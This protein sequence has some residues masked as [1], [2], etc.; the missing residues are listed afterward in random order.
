MQEIS[1]ALII[2]CSSRPVQEK[3][4]NIYASLILHRA[5]PFPLH[6]EI[7]PPSPQLCT[8]SQQYRCMLVFEA[9]DKQD[10][11]DLHSL[12]Q[13]FTTQGHQCVLVANSHFDYLE[14]ALQTGIGN[15]LL[16]DRF[17]APMIAALTRR[18]LGDDFFGFK[19]FFP[20]PHPR[21]DK[22]YLLEGNI[23]LDGLV[24]RHFC[25]FL[26]YLLGSHRLAFQTQ[27]SELVINALTYGVLGIT[28]EQRDGDVSNI[29][30][31]INITP[32]NEVRVHLLQDSEKY[33][34]SVTDCSGSLTSARILHKMRRH[35]KLPH[36]EFP[37]G[38]QDL[39]GRGLYLMSRQTRLVVNV[40]HGISTEV[41]LMYYFEAERNR[42]QSLIINERYPQP[43]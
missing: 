3:L 9:T 39:T 8:I 26:H 23:R 2:C 37:P 4:V 28:P 35:T 42:Y 11:S 31:V 15:I 20:D 10:V 16:E 22:H 32:G 6:I 24:E 1:K 14:L 34:I 7:N 13:R 40:L 41:I 29:P 38:I 21:F 27:I 12:V 18:L 30:R 36:E 5:L 43:R 19:P 17:D 25:D 33:G